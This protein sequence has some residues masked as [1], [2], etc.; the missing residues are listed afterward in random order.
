MSRPDCEELK[1]RLN[2][3][4]EDAL[5]GDL[6]ASQR[7]M[8][9]KHAGT[10][11]ECGEL[12]RSYRSLLSNLAAL[13]A[14]QAPPDLAQVIRK[15]I[16]EGQLAPGE[17]IQAPVSPP[18]RMF[19]MAILKIAAFLAVAAGA[20]LITDHYVKKTG[21][22]PDSRPIHIARAPGPAA[23]SESAQELPAK[24]KAPALAPGN[25]EQD[26]LAVVKLKETRMDS[27]EVE[28]IE[29]NLQAPLGSAGASS[30]TG[31][32]LDKAGTSLT[33]N[34]FAKEEGVFQVQLP[35]QSEVGM[36]NL[37]AFVNSIAATPHSVHWEDDL[38]ARKRR[39][40]FEADLARVASLESGLL[41]FTGGRSP[42]WGIRGGIREGEQRKLAEEKAQLGKEKDVPEDLAMGPR[43]E[44]AGEKA[45]GMMGEGKEGARQ[46]KES[47]VEP[48]RSRAAA[49]DLRSSRSRS[50]IPRRSS[51]ARAAPEA[52]EPAVETPDRVQKEELLAEVVPEEKSRE[53]KKP[54]EVK[55][56]STDSSGRY[57]FLPAKPVE[58]AAVKMAAPAEGDSKPASP[59]KKDSATGHAQHLIEEPP[60]KLK[61]DSQIKDLSFELARKTRGANP[62]GTVRVEILV[63]LKQE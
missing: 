17:L 57:K 15:R 9:L 22:S 49:G 24:I 29:A 6:P 35:A 34:L 8:L 53:V 40:V 19:G 33:R 11:P 61:R 44:E 4:V 58:Q 21:P 20:W 52:P 30:P 14:V 23:R 55:R 54:E 36:E 56:P 7:E 43:L 13:P 26:Q 25:V 39:I 18:S 38:N 59:D 32:K 62:S 50:S 1:E 63:D 47:R 42:V 41:S 51:A 5:Q 48:Q 45:D 10:C 46:G 2:E 37:L 27:P 12:L 28:A 16:E 60:R 31:E 3:L